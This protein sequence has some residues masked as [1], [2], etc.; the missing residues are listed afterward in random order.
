MVYEEFSIPAIQKEW[1]SSFVERYRLFTSERDRN[2]T[3]EVILR[4]GDPVRNKQLH[5]VTLKVYV[6]SDKDAEQLMLGLNHT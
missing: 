6:K 5:P 1:E 2:Y 3:L 4:E